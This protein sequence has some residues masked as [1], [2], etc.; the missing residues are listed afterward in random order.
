MKKIPMTFNINREVA[1]E[2]RKLCI[3]K[4]VTMSRRVEI[5]IKDGI[6]RLKELQDV[7]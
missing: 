3:K 6:G 2:F 1:N 7:E 4:G 5:Y